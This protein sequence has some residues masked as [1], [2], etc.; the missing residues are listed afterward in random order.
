[1]R[2]VYLKFINTWKEEAEN[3]PHLTQKM[4]NQLCL[5]I[6]TQTIEGIRITS[7]HIFHSTFGTKEGSGILYV[8]IGIYVSEDFSRH[9]ITSNEK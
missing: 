5:S 4:R 1:M 3:T 8:Y 9:L 6:R 2:N 7:K